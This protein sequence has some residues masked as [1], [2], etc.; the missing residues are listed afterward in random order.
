MQ[1]NERIGRRLKLRDLHILLAV[2]QRGSMAR[3]ASALAMSQPAVSKAIADVERELGLRLLD[4]TSRGVEPTRYGHALIKRGLAIFDELRQ[5]VHEL[6]FLADPS[7]GELRIGSS[8]GMAA[9][10]LPAIIGR[11][12][13]SHPRIVFNVT[14]AVF[15]STQYRDLRER[16][17]DLLLGRVFAPLEEDDLTVEALFEDQVAVVAAKRS[18]LARRRRLS[19]A[20]LQEERWVLHPPETPAGHLAREIFLTAGLKVP[21]APVLTLSIH[22]ALKLAATGRFVALLPSSVLR[23]ASQE[24]ALSVLPIKLPVQSRTVGIITLKNRTLS[25]LA[26]LFIKYARKVVGTRPAAK[27]SLR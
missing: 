1:W 18:P 12:S 4:R 11:V 8:E 17:V 20:D 19:L 14:Q 10:L 21:Q 7:V 6:D 2:A 5:G 16:T 13:Q 22:L 23:F 24:W 9:G 26:E 25:P 3:A 15:A 27:T